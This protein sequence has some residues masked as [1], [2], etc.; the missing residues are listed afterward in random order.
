M[1]K[2]LILLIFY[3]FA[4]IAHSNLEPITL[5]AHGIVDGPTQMNR[6]LPAIA[7]IDSQAIAFDDSKP[8]KGY[9]PT[10]M[11]STLASKILGKNVNWP[12]M[13]MGQ[14]ADIV[15][16][17][18]AV[19]T[20]DPKQPLILYGCSRGAATIINFMAEHNP[21]NVQALILDACPADMPATIHPFLTKFGI[22]KSYA[23]SI[24]R[25]IFPS[26][27][28]NVIQ[29]IDAISSITNKKIPILLLHS[30][31]DARVPIFHSQQLYQKFQDCGFCNVQLIIIP[32]GKHSFLLQDLRSF[33]MYLKAVHSFCFKHG[34]PHNREYVISSN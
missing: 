11:L 33:D 19:N 7:T 18:Q 32:E 15:K 29:P 16:I 25:L 22:N 20:F 26:Y 6:F 14:G 5:Y 10:S 9:M 1:N 12:C 3:F 4:S 27:P 31:T 23:E 34:L 28:A 13:Y 24:F 8:C 21:S 2:S 30:K 17:T